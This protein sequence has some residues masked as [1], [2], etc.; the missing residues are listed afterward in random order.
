LK[1]KGSNAGVSRAGKEH[2]GRTRLSILLAA[3]LLL[4]VSVVSTSALADDPG[5][6]PPLPTS[7]ETA[8]AI[9]EGSTL[10]SPQPTDPQAAAALPH[11]DL[12]R[13]EAVELL[14]GVFEPELQNAA[15][16]F[17]DLEVTRFLAPNVAVVP[18]DELSGASP[19][20]QEEE[21]PPPAGEDEEEASPPPSGEEA[22]GEEEAGS[23]GA[24]EEPEGPTQSASE[25]PP[26]I[27][28]AA[29]L[30]STIPLRAEATSG[31]QEPIDLS[32]E[33]SEGELQP[34]NPLVEVAIPQA[35][36]EG[37]ELPG[38]GVKIELAEAPEDRSPSTVEGSVAVYPNVAEDTDLAVA[39]TPTGVEAMT[40]LRSAESPL[41]Q[42]Y[43]L[44]LP[45]GAS[46]T[47][48]EEGGAIVKEGEEALLGIS[49]PTALDASGAKVPVSLSVSGDSLTVSTSPGASASYP[50]LVDPLFQS[51]NW[52]TM[53]YYQSG[54]CN[55]SFETHAENPCNNREEWGYEDIDH[56]A[57]PFHIEIN[58]TSGMCGGCGPTGIYISSDNSTTVGDRGTVLYTVPRYFKD[59]SPPTSYIGHL[60]LSNLD[61]TAISSH[62]SPY[63]FAGI[64]DPSKGAW[65]SYY[66]HE[67][68]VEH[69]VHEPNF[70]Y[71]FEND[72]NPDQ[73]IRE[74][75]TH[76]KV[77]EV[78]VQTTE[79]ASGT[80]ARVYV[81][82]ATVELGDNDA[83]SAPTA[84]LPSGWVNQTAPPLGFS[85][86][87]TGLG[88]YAVSAST[89]QLNSEGKPL[90]S[91]SASY[92]CLG[93]GD[94]ACPR[95]WN[96]SESGHPALTYEPALLPQGIDY[97]NVVAEDPVGN[98]SATTPAEVKV[99]HTPPTLSLSGTATEQAQLGT[100]LPEY[101]LKYS[102]A[103]GIDGTATAQAPFGSLGSG[104]GQL[105][106]PR[107]IAADGKGH[108]WVVD[109]DNNRVEEF[110]EE[111]AYIGQFG[112]KGS[113]NGQFNEPAGIALT[114]AGN[115]WVADTGNGRLE[116][117]SPSGTYMQQF[118]AKGA[119]SSGTTFVEPVRVAAAPGGMLWVSDGN[120][121]R[122]AE[123]RES[124]EGGAE[125]WVRDA[126][127]SAKEA[128]G[129]AEFAQPM[130]LA[131]DPSGA[132]LYVADH[133]NQRI[134]KF[135]ATTG[136][137]GGQFGS[138]G[139]GPGQLNEPSDI[140][141]APSGDL[142]VTDQENNRAEEF[143]PSGRFIRKFGSKGTGNANLSAPRGITF[144]AGNVVF[145][146]DK[147]N[148]RIAKWA[149]A[150]SDPQSG[151]AKA[152]VK[153]DGQ[154][155]EEFA[156]GCSTK[157]CAF[158]HEWGLKANQFTGGKHT[159]EVIA[160]DAVGLAT[161]KTISVEVHPDKV[162]PNVALA[163]TMIQ[164]GS[165][166][167][168]RPRYKIKEAASDGP[169][170]EF[171]NPAGL[172]AAYSFDEGSG[173][174]AHDLFGAH[175]AT[176]E[177]AKWTTSKFGSA[178]EFNPKEHAQL[179]VGTASDLKLKNFTLEAWVRPSE[180]RA[181]APLI[182]KTNPEDYG[183]ALY[184]GGEL[185]G[186]PEGL[187]TNH[188]S[189]QSYAFSGSALPTNA[190]TSL[191]LTDDG[192]NLRLYVNG[193]LADTRSA[194][195]VQAGP[196]ELKIGAAET[197]GVAEYLAGKADELRIYNRALSGA[198][199]AADQAAPTSPPRQSGIA[200]TEIT[201]D[202]KAVDSSSAGCTAEN[203]VV[204]REWTLESSAYGA[205]KHT[206]LVKATD[207]FGNTTTKTLPIEVQKDTTKPTLEVSGELANAPQ[208]W[209]EQE[210]YGFNATATDGG[211]GVTSLLFKIDG[212]EVAS[213]SASCPDGGCEKSL[214]KQVSMATYAGGAHAAEVIATDGAGNT[215]TKKWT[216]NVD[217]EGHISTEEA[218]DTIEAAEATG[219]GEVLQ[220]EEEEPLKL[221]ADGEALDVAGG[222]V[223]TAIAKNPEDGVSME[224]L[225]GDAFD[226]EGPEEKAPALVPIAI[227][228]TG[229]SAPAS[230]VKPGPESATGVAA[231]T[232]G[233]ADTIIR[234]TYDGDLT[235]QTIRDSSAPES[236]S[237]TVNLEG[238][239][240]LQLLSAQFAQVYYSSGHPAFGISAEPASDAVG[241]AVPTELSV[242]EG[243]VLTLTVKHHAG[244]FVYPILA[245][246]GWEGGFVTTLIAGPKDEKELREEREQREREEREQREREEE[247]LEP[248]AG[249]DSVFWAQQLPN[250][251][252]VVAGGGG[253]TV[254]AP[255]YDQEASGG[256]GAS[257]VP[258][259][260]ISRP[261]KA[262]A[263]WKIYISPSTPTNP[264]ENAAPCNVTTNVMARGWVHG[265][266]H[267][268]TQP[269]KRVWWDN[270]R[271]GEITCSVD[272]LHSAEWAMWPKECHFAGE[273]LQAGANSHIVARDFWR[274]E[275]HNGPQNDFGYEVIC[276]PMYVDLYANGNV[277]AN[278]IWGGS[279]MFVNFG[280]ACQWPS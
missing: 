182:S 278:K 246:A 113:G 25:V 98:T 156:P 250:G 21:T 256:A 11:D 224:I 84:T 230:E 116:E 106:G 73:H 115:L 82:N 57:P 66:S 130:G 14:Q 43:H 226:G 2:A 179:K 273:N 151:A 280:D 221:E 262:P 235:F 129:K 102:A 41:S 191:A 128:S 134:Q 201:L 16:I 64:W 105:S 253:A 265:H 47:A 12:G 120:G 160:T 176:I 10:E 165:L 190:W 233:Q 104:N 232:T 62:L 137:Y 228:P 185:A 200:S 172:V 206:V 29:L 87:D 24:E 196:G 109:H 36:G 126:T 180:S 48:T 168:V 39:P 32:L 187:I 276:L 169:L 35:L 257:S 149:N 17:D 192:T 37:I 86:T 167:A 279:P 174:V 267:Y 101:K 247:G 274:V 31:E 140:A 91:W 214:S 212:K 124:T 44:K 110:S 46:L 243:D 150:D 121:N 132:I 77:A 117:F 234:P 199:V 218:I 159:V 20:A 69:G 40:Q 188:K 72:M 220:S 252:W 205:G 56:N 219:S 148:N 85:A 166:G 89:E 103:D 99:D 210:S 30:D 242:S 209:V 51:Y 83:P 194:A 157:D 125:R 175:N 237:W 163:G 208:G 65:V 112:S 197:F 7:S 5:S 155:V 93:V 13:G 161:T 52:P 118:G 143:Q 203:C 88:V 198:E 189:V 272:F 26:E 181:G 95:T 59:S 183:Y 239:E 141:V 136:K 146:A 108:V 202:G 171:P 158:S 50:I 111:G 63:L 153:V 74:P 15:G 135:D 255:E 123:F 1:A 231:N 78:S 42:T 249:Q 138:L 60:T 33:H 49:P 96:S 58:N 18:R 22:E 275:T 215:A 178:L 107:A 114:E 90:H 263:C 222:S 9:E 229:M 3:V 204:P 241:T 94:A 53:N 177:G 270:G 164:Q 119:T 8:A 248:G 264:N 223:P 61:W 261:F 70:Q 266:F 259:V 92:G 122:V 225:E 27:A 236:Y 45:S 240:T 6:G 195:N 67:G 173:T 251:S 38:S 277:S 271:E 54:I 100:N 4:L 170:E 217:P 76:A 71:Q 19:E 80:T 55:S 28:G 139:S 186:K 213:T 144:G 207:G 131:L 68:L 162:A 269:N 23:P 227:E 184:A 245:G 34:S 244:S 260:I 81:G 75:D 79:V 211:Y 142:L 258:K 238:G 193:A 133:N 154:K 216:I 268:E 254:G 97:L 147:A 152:E 127:G 145:I